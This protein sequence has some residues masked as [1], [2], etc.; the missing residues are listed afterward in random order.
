M[1]LGGEDWVVI[2]EE[3]TLPV[4]EHHLWEARHLYESGQVSEKITV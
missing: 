3:E 4:G 2:Q 1:T